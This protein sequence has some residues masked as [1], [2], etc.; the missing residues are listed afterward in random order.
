[1]SKYSDYISEI[2]IRAILYEV[3]TT[4][5]PGLVDRQNSGAHHDM[6]YFTF[7]ASTS[8]ITSGI[9]EVCRIAD[10]FSGRP[11]DL[12]NMIRVVGVKTERDM[13]RTTKN[14]NTHKGIIFSMSLMCVAAIQV[15]KKAHKDGLTSHHI[16][17]YIMR[18]VSG[19]SQ[20]LDYKSNLVPPTHGERIYNRYG[21]KGIRGEAE[22]GFLSV[23]KHGLIY[24][25][26]NVHKY[27][28]KNDLFIDVLFN[29][30]SVCNDTNILSRHDLETLIEVQGIAKDFMEVGGML[31]QGALS[32]VKDIDD[33]F[34]TRNISPGG[35]ADLLAVTIF[36]GLL[37]GIIE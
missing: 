23:M 22:S 21:F 7:L 5:K 15:N 2:A 10:E 20:E 34:I 32:K 4:P 24:L 9:H 27:N 31:K 29:L 12:F 33:L 3:S 6:D 18:M 26:K 30:M 35:A 8:A 25:R 36:I 28:N 14:V 17:A 13:F 19:I 37:E 16:A 11:K 1:M